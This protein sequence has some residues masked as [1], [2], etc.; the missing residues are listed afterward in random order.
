LRIDELHPLKDVS[1]GQ[2]FP[3]L[4]ICFKGRSKEEIAR[5]LMED[6]DEIEEVDQ[7][8][9]EIISNAQG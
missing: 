7:R 3:I 6:D 8:L 9:T 5:N 2:L 1:M 4:S